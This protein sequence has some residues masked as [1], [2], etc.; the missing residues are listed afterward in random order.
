MELDDFETGFPGMRLEHVLDIADLCLAHVA[1]GGEPNLRSREFAGKGDEIKR[2]IAAKSPPASPVSWKALLGRLGRLQR[3]RVFDN[4]AAQPLDYAAMLREGSVSIIDLSDTDSP[5]LNN[6]AIAA[7]LRGVQ[8]EQ[9]RLYA[10]AER[11]ED[12]P[13]RT[14]VIIEEAHEFL[15]R[16]RIDK[17]PHLF[18]QVSRIAKRGRKRWL[19]LVFV[20]QLPQH[21]PNQVI[22]LVNNWVIHKI[23]DSGV[24]TTLQ[25]SVGGV[26]DSLW[27]RLP[28]LAP[29][30]AIVTF[31]HMHRPVLTAIDPDPAKLRM[32]D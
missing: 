7:I 16:E 29:G 13:P 27:R 20:T 17:M 11:Q 12:A 28:N 8:E 19:G 10:R 23:A 22:G 9:E 15:G 3:L 26:D 31:T 14:L 6:L 4:P 5:D 32:V 18:A 24:I 25:R 21:L 1:K 30:Q 2:D